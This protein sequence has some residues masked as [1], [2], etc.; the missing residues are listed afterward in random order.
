MQPSDFLILVGRDSGLPSPLAYLE[1]CF[2]WLRCPSTRQ[3]THR[4]RTVSSPLRGLITGS[5]SCRTLSRKNEDL[6]G[7]WAVP[8]QACRSHTH[9]AGP[10]SPCPSGDE[11]A[12]FMATQPLDFRNVSV[13]GAA[14]LRPAR[15]RAYASPRSLLNTSQGSL[16]TCWLGS[17]RAG[18]SPAGRLFRVSV[19][20][21]FI[22][23]PL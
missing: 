14:T 5:P 7:Y 6:P 13:F 10:P 3:Q 17:N 2:R 15:S 9:P 23:L 19:A 18:L 4:A 22:L 21:Y 11:D 16:P 12:A 8:V 20:F 1:A